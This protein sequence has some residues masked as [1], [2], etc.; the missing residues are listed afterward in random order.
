M[1]G[2]V[3][4]DKPKGKSSNQVVGQVKKLFHQ[5]KVGHL[6]TL[7]P[8]ATGVLPVCIGK[9]T[10]LFD[11]FLSKE[12]TY[13][14]QFTF[15]AT[16]DTLDAEG[17]ILS[18]S[19]VVPSVDQINQ[20]LPKLT[21]EINQMPPKFSAK[22]VNGERAYTLARKG[23]EFELQ[24]KK[25]TIF[26]FELVKQVSNNIFEFLISCSSGT[27]IRSLARDLWLECGTLAYMSELRRVKAGQFSIDQA[28]KIENL[29]EDK[30]IPLEKV[31]ENLKSV[32]V[33]EKFYDK[34]KNGN[35]IKVEMENSSNF[36]LFCR[37]KLFGI[38]DCVDNLI[39]VRVNLFE[40]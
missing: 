11:M 24:P 30:I 23:V 37:N 1:N 19:N 28:V 26:K 31:L 33:D 17:V 34:L 40:E 25:V 6:G 38:A 29:T 15:G 9:A 13:V 32:S 12:K 14:A 10:K 5:K 4:I 3:V 27:Y 20:V 39:K 8:M 36:M 22:S 16:T 2:I 18:T 7:D 21:G 35:A